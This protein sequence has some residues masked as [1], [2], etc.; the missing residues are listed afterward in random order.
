M[1]DELT[2]SERECFYDG[3]AIER[4]RIR[5]ILCCKE[6]EAQPNLARQLALH[7]DGS[8]EDARKLMTTS[9]VAQ[10]A[11]VT[12]ALATCRREQKLIF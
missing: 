5:Q 6:A 4:E 9:A 7:W 2:D 12:A 8:V 1:T 11:D 3:A 10:L